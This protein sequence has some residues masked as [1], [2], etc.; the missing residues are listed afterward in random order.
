MPPCV[1]TTA[2]DASGRST[3]AASARSATAAGSSPPRPRTGRPRSSPRTARDSARPPRPGSGP[4]RAHAVLAQPGVPAQGHAEEIGE[5]GRGLHG[6]VEVAGDDDPPSGAALPR[7]GGRRRPR[8][9]SAPWRREVGRAAPGSGRRRSIRSGRAATAPVAAPRAGGGW[10]RSLP[11]RLLA[12]GG[13]RG[14]S[15][16]AAAELSVNGMVGQS[17]HSR[18]RA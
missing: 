13:C 12:G 6:A 15:G 3:S 7:P 1:T 11:G 4:P 14:V 17:F 16:P 18:S 2:T 9:L 8:R 10:S 5:G